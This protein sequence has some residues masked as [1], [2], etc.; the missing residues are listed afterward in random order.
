MD[1]HSAGAANR[2]IYFLT[3]I[4]FIFQHYSI[5]LS[6]ITL[7][8]FLTLFYFTFQHNYI[9]LAKK[10]IKYIQVQYDS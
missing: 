3:I 8:Y 10:F 9:I 7:F 1:I 6:N 2:I 5:L 4:Y